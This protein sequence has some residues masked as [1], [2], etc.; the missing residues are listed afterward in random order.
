[1]TQPLARIQHISRQFHHL[2]VLADIN[3]DIQRGEVLGIVGPSG[4]GK[5]TILRILSGFDEP[6]KGSVERHFAKVGF[7]FQE[8]RL[9]NWRTA[10]ENLTLVLPEEFPEKDEIAKNF[11]AQVGLTGFEGYYPAQLS[12]GMRQRVAIARA[13]IINP[14]LLLLDEPF[15]NLDFALRLQMVQL[16]HDL[17]E[18]RP[19]PLTA[20]YVT[21]DLREALLLSNRLI[22]LSAIPTKIQRMIELPDLPLSERLHSEELREIEMEI[23]E[24]L[25]NLSGNKP[26]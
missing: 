10:L 19:E 11:L 26:R 6:D 7:V 5:S 23:I 4:C 15:S 8:P 17:I 12:G 18:T 2:P 22:L 9:L 20:I 1:M 13:L 3:I 16:L 25:L 24:S 14:D 21:H